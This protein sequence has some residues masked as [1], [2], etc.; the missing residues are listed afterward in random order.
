MTSTVGGQGPHQSLRVKV[1]SQDATTV[2]AVSGE[3]DMVTA[4]ELEQAVE[5][6]L[7]SGPS[8]LVVDL[9]QVTFLASAGLA[10]LV[11]SHKRAGQ[12]T[13]LRIV[14]DN[15]HTQ[16]PLQLMGLDQE[17]STYASRD[18]ALSGDVV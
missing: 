18:E 17:L 3:I 1:E 5:R 2:L 15:V 7:T 4:P 16:R 12:A 14:A 13:S 9:A 8:T 11:R 6:A 10:V